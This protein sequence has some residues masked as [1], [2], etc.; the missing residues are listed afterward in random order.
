[1]I[2]LWKGSSDLS[3]GNEENDNP[4][5]ITRQKKDDLLNCYS[6]QLIPEQHHTFYKNLLI[7]KEKNDDV[8]K[9]RK[10][11]SIAEKVNYI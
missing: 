3:S 6:T 5:S 1:M 7:N 9:P 11:K 2:T 8:P 10:C 4:V